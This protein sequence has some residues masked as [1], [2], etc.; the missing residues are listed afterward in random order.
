MRLL[1]RSRIQRQFFELPELALMTR[2]FVGP[3]F[4]NDFESFGGALAIVISGYS[5]HAIVHLGIART[6]AKFQS[7]AGNRVDHG[8]IFRGMKRMAQRQNS[9]AGAEAN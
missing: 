6:N 8:V 7:A 1:H 5:E 4:Q 2:A 3:D 9:N